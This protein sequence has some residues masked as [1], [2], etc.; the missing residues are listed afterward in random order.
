MSKVAYLT[1]DDGPTPDF[2]NKLD[3]LTERGIIAVWFCQGNHMEARP[4]A[5]LEAIRRGH[6][7]A[8]HGYSHPHFSDIS[9]DQARAEI[10]ATSTIIDELYH[11]AGL[12]RR[13]RFFRFPYGDKGDRLYGDTDAQPSA[14]GRARKQAIQAYLRHLGYTQPSWPDVTYAYFDAQGL[15]T[16][17][18]WYWTYDT[19]DWAPYIDDAPVG[20]NSIARVMARLDEDDPEGGRGLNDARSSE[21]VLVH[22]NAMQDNHLFVDLIEAILAKGIRFAHPVA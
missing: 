9:V 19:F 1:I 8:N 21:I 11:R 4:E 22:D 17:V 5:I 6:I 20:V 15:R 12:P 16:D 18:D 3:Y 14:E 13:Y 7:I 10:R 2:L